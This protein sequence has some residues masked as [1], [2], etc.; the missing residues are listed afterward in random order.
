MQ[1][2]RLIGRRI[3]FIALLSSLLVAALAA[4]EQQTPAALQQEFHLLFNRIAD[5]QERAGIERLAN[6]TARFKERWSQSL[7]ADNQELAR[8]AEILEVLLQ[9][10]A[11]QLDAAALIHTD[12]QSAAQLIQNAEQGLSRVS[13]LLKQL[14]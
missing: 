13:E 9:S 3:I 14:E 8:R 6:E 1:T 11:D 4:C 7:G 10:R 5:E 12:P 2:A